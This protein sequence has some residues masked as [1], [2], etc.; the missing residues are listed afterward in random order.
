MLVE[1]H[2][3]TSPRNIC[4]AT[5]H[6]E[7]IL[8]LS[9]NSK[10]QVEDLVNK[11]LAAGRQLANDT[12]GPRLHVRMELPEPPRSMDPSALGHGLYWA[13]SDCH[14]HVCPPTPKLVPTSPGVPKKASPNG[15]SSAA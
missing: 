6:T 5:T 2:F 3:K 12:Y 8:A 10:E 7:V 11:A 15:R 14:S 4:D 1:D 13:K 9:A